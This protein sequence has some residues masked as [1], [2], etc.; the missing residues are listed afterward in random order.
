MQSL[1]IYRALFD[2]TFD[3]QIGTAKIVKAGDKV[4]SDLKL[5]YAHAVGKNLLTL[6]STPANKKAR[7]VLSA[8]TC[9][10]GQRQLHASRCLAKQLCANM[11]H[12]ARLG[13][14]RLKQQSHIMV[15]NYSK[16]FNVQVTATVENTVI[17]GFKV[18]LAAQAPDTAKNVKVRHLLTLH[19]C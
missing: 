13:S 14:R 7:T 18:T 17:E 3:L 2:R 19:V 15:V 16:M 11:M 8:D 9:N 1:D 12:H 6:E 5:S 10:H 4:N